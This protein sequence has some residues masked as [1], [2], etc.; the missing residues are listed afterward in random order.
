M[1]LQA[2]DKENHE[3]EDCNLERKTIAAWTTIR[4]SRQVHPMY[5]LHAVNGIE[6]LPSNTHAGAGNEC[7]RPKACLFVR[8]K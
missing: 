7:M 8:P 1:E 4:L 6:H 3:Q 5:P 2:N